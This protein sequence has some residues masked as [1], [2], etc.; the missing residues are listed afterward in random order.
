MSFLQAISIPLS[1]SNRAI[2]CIN[3]VLESQVGYLGDEEEVRLEIASRYLISSMVFRRRTTYR[4]R[5]Q[6]WRASLSPAS[7]AAGPTPSAAASANND[8]GSDASWSS[9]RRTA[10]RITLVS[11]AS[12]TRWASVWDS[13]TLQ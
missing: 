3:V 6:S 2:K 7:G 12:S 13:L 10:G 8:S 5:W 4:R 9:T 1:P 11:M